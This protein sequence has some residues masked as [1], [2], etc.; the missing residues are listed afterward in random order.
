MKSF[1]KIKDLYKLDWKRIFHSK[2]TLLLVI[3]LMI[4]PSLYA[5]FN[6]KALW[7][8]YSNT[9][10]VSI[11]V[12]S[13]DETVN[14]MDKDINIGDEIISNL[15]DNDSLGWV[16]VNS[17]DELDEG[18][19]DGTFYAG[20]YMPD[21]FS[22][23]LISFVKGD[24][25]KPVIEYSVN[26]KINAIAP[27]I[28][29]KGASTLKDTITEQFIG[30][31]SETLLKVF[32]EIGF[33]LDS[34]IVS[35]NKISSKI[36]DIDENMD[37]I[38][39]Y[40]QE[41]V[42]LNSKVPDIKN[43][44]NKANSF[45]NYF[46][47][48]NAM[49]DKLIKANDLMPQIEKSGSLILTLQEKIP[50]IQNAGKQINMIDEDFDS[51]V[52]TMNKAID[53][54]KSGIVIIT[55]AQKVLPEVKE[56]TITANN[57]LLGIKDNISD[58]KNALP[59]ISD[60]LESGINIVKSISSQTAK[61]TD[62]LLNY[63]DE[64]NINDGDKENIKLQL[65][66]ISNNLQT[67]SRILNSSIDLM[68][69][70]EEITNSN[71][72]NGIIN[73]LKKAKSLIDRLDSRVNQLIVDLDNVSVEDIK[74]EIKN[75][76][77]EAIKI[78]NIVNNIN[79]KEIIQKVNATLIEVQS[80]L[81]NANNITSIIVDKNLIDRIDE[82]MDETVGI[83]NEV[84]SFMEKYEKEI[85]KVKEEIHSANQILNGNMDMIIT[86]INKAADVYNNDLPEI[87][88]KLNKASV[89]VKEDLPTVESD[90]TSTLKMANDKFPDVEN[91]L[92][93]A[94]NLINEDL[95][96][97]KTGIH[98][99][100]NL[101]RSGQ[102]DIDLK[103]II[104]ILKSD[105]KA[106]SDFLANPVEIEQTDIY[107]IPN[108]GSASTPFYTAL[109]LWVGALLLASM[110]STEFYLE[111]EDKL[112]YTKRE[113]FIAR[114]LTYYTIGLFQ[115]LVVTL[116]NLFLL[117]VYCVSPVYHVL[118]S[119]LVGFTFMTMVY[120]LVA[121]MGNLGKGIAVIILVLSISGGGGNFPIEMSGPFFR[122]IN[123][124]LPFTYAVDLIRESVGGIYW[125]N[126]YK[127]ILI[128]LGF[129][130]V[131]LIVGTIVYPP[132]KK[133]FKKLND[134]LHE[135]HLLH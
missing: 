27:K 80:L 81:N 9:K 113:Q 91:A 117:G 128:L 134:K 63:I 71:K 104:K 17:K 39:G 52:D 89:F 86:G 41:I 70:L 124:L 131:F 115:S 22:D 62:A 5:W 38:D 24:I 20:I 46:P 82:L 6:I 79:S 56:M 97:I 125:P 31:A 23:N 105:A 53:E 16:F 100:A 88:A 78:N 127:Y 32:N 87:K 114:L 44:L 90:L 112:R 119:I 18:V 36:I 75:I 92:S 95:P 40:A 123:P 43:K 103:E 33:Q 55:D 101:I 94:T 19:K 107:P 111:G 50:E 14:L 84:V 30:T 85:P 99:A 109:C 2:L 68:E 72:L 106:E 118:F 73:N 121:L 13:D 116:G 25:K 51:I 66:S 4:I 110:A 96:N 126:A 57:M 21:N 120:V 26:Q 37:T 28:S 47:E 60:G 61:L 64:N 11:A 49:G 67:K 42:S 29:D 69:K 35:I 98:K 108:Y 76:N 59:R 129:A 132:V 130:L 12:L 83:I 74:S 8:P 135:G 58:I 34:N 3:A 102:E 77:K 45:I 65:G 1:K 122:A 48:V 54:A 7:D 93:M 133:Y 10:D 15:K